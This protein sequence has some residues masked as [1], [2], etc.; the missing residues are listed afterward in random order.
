MGSVDQEWLDVAHLHRRAGFAARPGELED[1]AAR[2]FS[3]E[4]LRMCALG[5]DTSTIPGPTFDSDAIVDGLRS[6]DLD[7]RK[8]A[9]AQ[10]RRELRD[11]IVW[12]LRRMVAADQPLR[13]KLTWFWHGH[14]ATSIEKVKLPELMYRQN[15]MFR[16]LGSGPFPELVQAVAVDP[17]MLKWLDGALNIKGA[18]NENFAREVMEL[19]T[20]GHGMSMDGHTHQPYTEDDVKAGAR[21][22]T[23]TR[24]QR[25]RNRVVTVPA[26]HDDGVKTYLGQTG[27]WNGRD[28]VRIATDDPASIPFVVSRLWSRLARPAMPDDPVVVELAEASRPVLDI[29]ALVPRLFAHDEFRSDAT[30]TGLVKQPVEWLVGSCRSLGIDPHDPRL[31]LP[32]RTLGQVPFA[33][34]SVGGWPSN[35]AWLTTGAAQ[36]RLEIASRLAELAPDAVE[37]RGAAAR[38]EAMGRALGIGAWTQATSEALRSA[39]DDPHALVTLALVAPEHLLA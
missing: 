14:F 25:H 33:P 19:F 26:L 2:G 9:R 30:R 24:F 36:A 4:L 39:A 32:L 35:R 1:A 28:I 21:A 7:A 6:A 13:E 20:L 31:V 18:P 22:V 12:W 34:P 29:G 27:R 38:V 37:G 3:E 5:P 11:L 8:R 15:S 16:L 23:G 10:V 17:A